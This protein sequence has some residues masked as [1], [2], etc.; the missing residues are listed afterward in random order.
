MISIS[1]KSRSAILALTE[2]AQHGGAGPVPILE[3]AEARRIP[4]H[5]LEQL[6]ASLRRAG[7][8]ASQRGVKG[9][10]SF[11]RPP[12][13]VTVLEVVETVDGRL[14]AP[15]EGTVPGGCE[16]V[17][18]EARALLGDLLGGLTVSDMAEREARLTR[19]PMFHI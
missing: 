19:A 6:F 13:E 5:V 15:Q 8:L 10:Y 2:L 7:I 12:E 3:I 17:W 1:E 4:V 18:A 9:G 11:R 16:S 14:G